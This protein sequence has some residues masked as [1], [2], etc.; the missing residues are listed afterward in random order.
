MNIKTEIKGCVS[1][2]CGFVPAS[3]QL[4][5][6]YL[7]HCSWLMNDYCEPALLSLIKAPTC[8]NCHCNLQYPDGCKYPA[9]I[10]HSKSKPHLSRQLY[11]FSDSHSSNC[12]QRPT[13]ILVNNLLTNRSTI[14]KLKLPFDMTVWF[15]LF[16]S[17][18]FIQCSRSLK[19]IF[20]KTN[21][22]KKN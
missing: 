13:A 18:H 10:H 3:F 4:F 19:R 12:S 20:P 6:F 1:C 2:L 16:L 5:W 7:H 9:N 11:P 14:E 17:V 22:K 8:R 21:K 15:Y